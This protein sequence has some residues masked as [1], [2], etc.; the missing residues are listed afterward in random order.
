MGHRVSVLSAQTGIYLYDLSNHPSLCQDT[1]NQH[2]QAQ[3]PE[4]DAQPSIFY[5]YRDPNSMTDDR[6]N[7]SKLLGV[8]L[9]RELARQLAADDHPVVINT[10]V[11][12]FVRTQISR[13][14]P[15][16]G[17]Y[18]VGL[19]MGLIGR[20]AEMGSRT[21]VHAAGAGRE[22]HGRLLASCQVSEESVSEFAK[23]EE[24]KRVGER[25]FGELMGILEV[26]VPGVQGNVTG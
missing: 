2:P 21:L 22:S 16:P 10:V 18:V 15:P 5:T 3:F 24:G 14:V 7:T 20:T 12:G 8:L 23:S 19:M 17:K 11:P 9:S 6:Y 25:V 4:R 26:V 1:A 13:N